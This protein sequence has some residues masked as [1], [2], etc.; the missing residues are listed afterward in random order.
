MKIALLNNLYEP[1][2]RGGAEKVVKIMAE[3]LK[4]SGHEI[5][6]ITTEPSFKKQRS[7]K[8][9]KQFNNATIEQ[10]TKIYHINSSYYNLNSIPKALRFF[11]HLSDMFSL[12][13]YFTI[14]KIL[15][16]EKPDLAITHNLKGL[17]FLAP[18]ALKKSRIKHIHYLHDIQLL[19]PSGLMF[20]GQERII[21]TLTAKI[22][23][24]FNH[25]LF[26]SPA[27]I[28]SPSHWLMELHSKFFSNSKKIIL[29][30]P[31]AVQKTEEVKKENEFFNWLFVGQ[32]EKHKG[33]FF[34][35]EAFKKYP[36]QNCSLTIVGDGSQSEAIRALAKEDSRIKIEPWP[37]D[38]ALKK[39]LNQAD[40][41]IMPSLCYENSPTIIYD[42][43]TVGLPVIASDLGGIPEL[44]NV[45]GGLLFAPGNEKDLLSKMAEIKKDQ[46]LRQKCKTQSLAKLKDYD[47]KIYLEKINKIISA[48]N[49]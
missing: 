38:S 31:T 5:F 46:E 9:K 24:F 36:D 18:L 42:S 26:D 3:E 49:S 4:K 27:I 43:A 21:N 11:W 35:L 20:A 44:S 39:Y 30:N 10:S 45:F 6:I 37:G 47:L 32:I 2:N 41:L 40:C 28:I 22:Y 33:I 1:Y 13:K 16:R 19:H 8:T 34:L 17:G 48:N 29:P 15:K 23:Q 12:R 7:K 14:R 25:R